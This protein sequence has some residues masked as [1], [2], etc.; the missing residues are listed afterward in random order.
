[1]LQAGITGGI[2]SGKTIVA[3]L[4]QCLGVPVYDADSHAK[5]LMTT[6]GKLRHAIAAEFGTLSYTSEGLLNR[7]HLA[8]TVF[9]Q[10]EK[11]RKLNQLVHPAVAQDYRRWVAEQSVWAPSYVLKE[12]ALL[13]SAEAE[14][15]SGKVIVVTAPVETRVMRV[16]KR[17]NRTEKE[18]RHIMERQMS[19]EQMMAVADYVVINDGNTALIP[20]VLKIHASLTDLNQPRH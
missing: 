9:P 2:G 7:E 8:A 20:Q 19:G 14:P 4:F 6:D 13:L 11:L 10:P 1:M 12:A 18:I 3:R 17:D 15:F 5:K 16:A